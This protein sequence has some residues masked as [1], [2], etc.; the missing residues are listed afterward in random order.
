MPRAFKPPAEY[1]ELKMCELFG[2][3]PWELDDE[4]NERVQRLYALHVAEQEAFEKR[5]G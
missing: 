2:C 5:R 3:L 4:E 1:A